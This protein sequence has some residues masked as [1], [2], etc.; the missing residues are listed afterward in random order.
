MDSPKM[1]G[2]C[3]RDSANKIYCPTVQ[4]FGGTLAIYT[5]K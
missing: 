3:L 2:F 1:T 5:P 4:L